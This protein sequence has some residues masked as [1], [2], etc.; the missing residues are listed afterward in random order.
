MARYRLILIGGVLLL[1]VVVG[2]FLSLRQPP[3]VVEVPPEAL[4]TATTAPRPTALPTLVR[5]GYT[6]LPGTDVA[7]IVVERSPA[8]GEELAPDQPL[9]FVFDREMD[10]QA[11]GGA[12]AISPQIEGTFA[13]SDA[14][15]VSFRPEKPW[16]RNAV[17]D[18]VLGQAAR[19]SDG[20][21]LESPYQFRFA[22]SGYLEVA[23]AIPAPSASDIAATSSI[24]VLF[25]RPVVALTTV[26]E[27]PGLPQPLQLVAAGSTEP[28]AGT[29]EWLNT[30]VYLF[31]PAAA[32][33][34]GQR[35][36]GRIDPALRDTNGNPIQAEFTWQFAVATPQVL[37]TYPQADALLVDVDG[38]LRIDFN[39][40]VTQVGAEVRLRTG[41]SAVAGT[42]G[43]L[44]ETLIFTPSARL[45]FDNPI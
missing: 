16:N 21:R 14:R 25:N 36:T 4:P 20:A 11:V 33:Q 8:R 18:V 28:V 41:N 37:S 22:T 42:I 5:P 9:T 19:A 3:E 38:V 12:L 32:L 35:Y 29:G 30:S 10:Q 43:A 26:E 27:Q 6:A 39:Q 15:T 2:V 31:R 17:Y 44:G 7:P 45:R 24:T 23:Q 40:P 34:G 1:V 13:W